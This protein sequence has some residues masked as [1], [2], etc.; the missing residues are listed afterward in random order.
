VPDLENSDNRRTVDHLYLEVTGRCTLNCPHCAVRSWEENPQDPDYE[1]L[2]TL[3]SDFRAQGGHYVTFSGGEPGLRADLPDLISKAADLGLSATLYTNGLAVTDGVMESLQDASG[4]MAVSLDGPNADAHEEMRGSGTYA[5]ALAGFKKAVVRLGGDRVMLSC[6]LSK[7]LLPHVDQLWEFA[8]SHRVGALYLNLFEPLKTYAV[9][10]LAPAAHELIGPVLGLLDAAE[11]EDGIR[12]LFSESHDLICVK[13]VFSEREN[14]KIL[15]RTVKVQ[16]GGWAYPG[17][18]FYD[19]RFRLGRPA[20]QGWPAILNSDVYSELA[21]QARSR[22]GRVPECSRC[23]WAARCGG[24]SLALSWA[25]H[26][27][28]TEACPLCELYKATLDRAARRS[29]A[30]ET[31]TLARQ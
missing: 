20:E 19:S 25:T 7:P 12:L 1:V 3:L 8:L 24:G 29:L 22:A 2:A 18:F 5:Q 26:G 30:D 21:H 17:P 4:L 9:H 15:G 16:A 11:K 28:W 27:K 10:S 14:Q 23:F 13:S 31:H 6:I